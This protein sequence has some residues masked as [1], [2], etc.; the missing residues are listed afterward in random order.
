MCAAKIARKKDIK[1]PI[2]NYRAGANVRQAEIEDLPLFTFEEL[3]AAT[4]NFSGT[5]K[6]GQGGFGPVYKV[7]NKDPIETF[8]LFSDRNIR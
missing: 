1:W 4:N 6:L 2:A 3:V 7:V 8:I 5:N